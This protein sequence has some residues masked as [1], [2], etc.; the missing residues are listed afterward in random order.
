[1]RWLL[2]ALFIVPALEIGVFIWVG[3]MIGPWWVVSLI[4]LSG[5][6]GIT[7]AKQQGLETWI[8]ARQAINNGQVPRDQITDGIC[9]F[10][11]AVF[12]F[13]PGFITDII[14]ILLIVP[15]TRIPFK[16][17]LMK[18]IAWKISKRTIIY[19]K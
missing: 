18:W 16:Q 12:L 15:W 11:G 17:F 9:I 4:I 2:L 5:I 14:G 3:G 8:R 1:M 13:A 7:Y 19:R 6:I 10:I